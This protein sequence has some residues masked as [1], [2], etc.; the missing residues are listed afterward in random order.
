MNGHTLYIYTL[1]DI[2]VYIY[3]WLVNELI[4]SEL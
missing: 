3:D 2:R 1:L 4:T